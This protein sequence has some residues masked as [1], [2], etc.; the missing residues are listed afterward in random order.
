MCVLEI[1]SSPYDIIMAGKKVIYFLSKQY[2]V[3]KRF[4]FFHLVS[5]TSLHECVT[6]HV[7][8]G[9][10]EFAV[11]PPRKRNLNTDPEPGSS[12][13]RHPNLSEHLVLLTPVRGKPVTES[14]YCF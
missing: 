10:K 9:T 7:S 11:K 13:P 2:G 3:L 6:Y 5:P 12:D 14:T 4:M 1:E 8:F